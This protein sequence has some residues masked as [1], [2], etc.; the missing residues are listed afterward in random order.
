MAGLS[1][2]LWYDPDKM[3]PAGATLATT[4]LM[5]CGGVFIA[6]R[7][8]MRRTRQEQSDHTSGH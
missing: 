7:L 5:I 6:R 3:D 1:S 8:E 2:L 4:V